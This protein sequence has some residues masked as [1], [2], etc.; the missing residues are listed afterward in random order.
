MLNERVESGGV[1]EDEV[2][3]TLVLPGN[4]WRKL[5]FQVMQNSSFF[6]YHC[7]TNPIFYTLSYS[8]SAP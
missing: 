6:H 2:I 5:T 1:L 3:P 7:I 4:S 8:K